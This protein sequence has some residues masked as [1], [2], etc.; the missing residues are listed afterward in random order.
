MEGIFKCPNCG[1]S[2]GLVELRVTSKFK[3]GCPKCQGLL[4]EDDY[5]IDV[6]SFIEM[7]DRKKHLWTN[8]IEDGNKF[9]IKVFGGNQGLK[10][11]GCID[12]TVTHAVLYGTGDT[13]EPKFCKKHYIL[14]NKDSRF[15]KE[16]G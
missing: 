5:S 1:W 6:F 10:C 14:A 2:G 16:K 3:V 8:V 11:E 15:I 4:T 13:R 12:D 9:D 7:P